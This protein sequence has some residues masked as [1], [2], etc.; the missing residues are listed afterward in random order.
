MYPT[1]ELAELAVRREYL[2]ARIALRRQE[3]VVAF[4]ELARPLKI[5]DQAIGHWR[6]IGPALK[7]LGI[8]LALLM[9]R[10]LLGR[11][12]WPQWLAVARALPTVMRAVRSYAPSRR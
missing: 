2:Q 9:G 3:A 4:H 6:R 11:F 5:I 1:G 12:R 10:K 7:V 8:P